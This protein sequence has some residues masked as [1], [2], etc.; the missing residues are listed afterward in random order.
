ML[1][2]LFRRRPSLPVVSIPKQTQPALFKQKPPWW[3]R[4][5][6]VLVA[7]DVMVASVSCFENINVVFANSIKIF[8]QYFCDRTHLELL[9]NNPGSQKGPLEWNRNAKGSGRTYSATSL[10]A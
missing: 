5:A 10:E 4:W 3:A 1:A 2:A 8:L 6:L 7:L 9:D